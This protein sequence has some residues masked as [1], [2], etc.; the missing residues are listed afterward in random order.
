MQNNSP[1]FRFWAIPTFGGPGVQVVLRK[2]GVTL[3]WGPYN[4][5]PI[6]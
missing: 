1:F 2:L 3:F 6:I 4:K 5:D